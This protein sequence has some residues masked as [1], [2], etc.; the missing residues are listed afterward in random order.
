[1][2]FYRRTSGEIGVDIGVSSGQIV[3]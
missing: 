2:R 1:V 3:A